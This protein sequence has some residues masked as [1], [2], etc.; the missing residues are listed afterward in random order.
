MEY[1]RIPIS[2]SEYS[3]LIEFAVAFIERLLQ[4]MR[5]SANIEY[6]MQKNYE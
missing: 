5:Y 4:V 6:Q 3:E 1:G 2:N